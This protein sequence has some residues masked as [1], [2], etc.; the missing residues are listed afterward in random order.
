MTGPGES[1]R[2]HDRTQGEHALSWPNP[3][4]ERAVMTGPAFRLPGTALR[5]KL[6]RSCV[7][8][9][10][11]M[12]RRPVPVLAGLLAVLAACDPTTGPAPDFDISRDPWI[13]SPAGMRVFG[14]SRVLVVLARF[15]DSPAPPLSAAD[16][17]AQLFAA[18]NGGPVNETFSLA[19]GGRFRLRGQV[20]SWV[21][22]TVTTTALFQAGLR[23]P[24]G[25]ED[26]VTD[27]LALVEGEV[28]FGRFDNEGPDGIPNSGDDD[29]MVDGGVVVLNTERNRYCDGGTGRGPHPFARVSWTLN[30]QPYATQDGAANGGVIR[31]GGFTLMSAIGCGGS[32]VS[33]NVMAHELGHLLFRLPDMYHVIGGAGEVWATR[34]WVV[35][36]WEL[37]AAGAWGCGTG[38][39]TLDYRFN[40]LGPWSRMTV[41]WSVPRLVDV[42][43][44]STYDLDPMDR[45]GTVL[46]V[47]I[48]SMEYLLI[49][50]RE[51]ASGDR[52]LPGNGVLLYHVDESRPLSTV[53][54]AGPYRVSL[55]EADDD[56][57]FHRTEL[58]G[59]NRGVAADAFGAAVTAFR[60]G[61][62]TRA[63][64][65]DGSP[66]PFQVTEISVNPVAHRARL[67]IAP[68]PVP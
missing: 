11:T 29:G 38:A 51:G 5:R 21:T 27:A 31:I 14:T 58:Q 1:T 55:V 16:V 15:A 19:S 61:M 36:C 13:V 54:A 57:A 62:H 45:G 10:I 42:G 8:P 50:Y 52:R 26:Y 20:T 34:R 43:K 59:G 32:T 48:T 66:L 25:I 7:L 63:R 44:D 40:T 30:G 67:R 35:G 18:G 17:R 4:S 60:A 37:M 65:N 47:P 2:R 49:E 53:T 33:A 46:K 6:A 64:A 41:G 23:T 12:V 24:S 9:P 39:P 56:S 68:A 28:D 3:A 22:T